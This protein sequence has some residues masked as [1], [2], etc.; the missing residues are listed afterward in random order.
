MTLPNGVLKKFDR[1]T[2]VDE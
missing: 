1:F 2:S